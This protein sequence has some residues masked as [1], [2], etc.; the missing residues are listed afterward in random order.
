MPEFEALLQLI[1]EN[2]PNIIK[3]VS[4]GT[5]F[6]P[7]L[8]ALL[9]TGR[10]RLEISL[11]CADPQLYK[12]IKGKALFNEV[13]ENLR[14][15]ACE[16]VTLK[17]ILMPENRAENEG[18]LFLDL[19][20]DLGISSVKI[21]TDYIRLPI[22]PVDLDRYAAMIGLA[23]ARGLS[24]STILHEEAEFHRYIDFRSELNDRKTNRLNFFNGGRG[25]PPP[26]WEE[27]LTDDAVFV[28]ELFNL[29]TGCFPEGGK[30]AELE[31]ELG[32]LPSRFHFVSACYENYCDPQSS[33]AKAPLTYSLL[34]RLYTLF[35]GKIPRTEEVMVWN[36]VRISLD[37]ALR[38]LI[39]DKGFDGALSLGQ[40]AKKDISRQDVLLLHALLLGSWPISEEE[41]LRYR[42][43]PSVD[44][45][46]AYLRYSSAFNLLKNDSHPARKMPLGD[47]KIAELGIGSIR[48][49]PTWIV[50][51]LGDDSNTTIFSF[52]K[53]W[54]VKQEVFLDVNPPTRTDGERP[55]L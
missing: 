10:A 41:I 25:E 5:V 55:V 33:W 1:A 32:R 3:V 37:C 29:M 40:E 26:A 30:Q 17:Y 19:A 45:L 28:R 34:W 48:T 24:V 11:D 53:N 2:S 54:L 8:D 12:K 9:K 38:W 44:S 21:T 31:R 39:T 36:E 47:K 18:R 4:N 15:Y 6:S 16:T 42:Q 13:I 52:W 49:L 46:A 27:L 35:W 22:A 51:G 14:R 43:H 7:M 50:K 20:E 23:E